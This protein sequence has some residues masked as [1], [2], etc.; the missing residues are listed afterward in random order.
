M[1]YRKLV[2]KPQR[3]TVSL[4]MGRSTE[5]RTP[6]LSAGWVATVYIL[7]CRDAVCAACIIIVLCAAMATKRDIT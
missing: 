7:Y 1:E 3:M 4:M 6:I 2:K 5:P